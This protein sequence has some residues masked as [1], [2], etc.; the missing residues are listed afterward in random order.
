VV[1]VFVIAVCL[2]A[3]AFVNVGGFYFIFLDRPSCQM[4]LAYLFKGRATRGGNV[5]SNLMQLFVN[6]I[7]WHVLFF[8]EP[9]ALHDFVLIG[10]SAI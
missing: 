1:F 7:A 6:V 8:V 3:P 10:L 5:G 4:L 9:S 2:L